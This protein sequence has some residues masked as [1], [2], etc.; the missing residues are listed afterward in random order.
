MTPFVEPKDETSKSKQ[1][2]EILIHINLIV[3]VPVAF[4][5]YTTGFNKYQLPDFVVYV[6]LYWLAYLIIIPIFYSLFLR[7]K[8][9]NN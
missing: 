2:I 8:K 4:L 5:E 3:L 1:I 6:Y 9:K 7:N